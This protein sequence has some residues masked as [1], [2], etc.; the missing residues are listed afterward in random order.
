MPKSEEI[1]SEDSSSFTDEQV[2]LYLLCRLNEGERV[3]FEERLL[4]GDE[5]AQR[6]R[7]AE[8]ELSDDYAADRLSLADRDFFE[9]KF[10]VSEGRRSDLRVSQALHKHAA[11]VS[12]EAIQT[13]KS[14][15]LQRVSAL[16]GFE[17]SPVFATVGSL[18]MLILIGGAVWL[19]VRQKQTQEPVVASYENAPS[20]QP[21]VSP[22]NQLSPTQ[23]APSPQPSPDKKPPTSPTPPHAQ[24]PP[25]VATFTLFPGSLRGSGD[26]LR[27]VV[28]SGKQDVVRLMLVPE[29]DGKGIYGAQ[30]LSA[31]G[32]TILTR[33]RLQITKDNSEPRLLLNIPAHQ[34]KVGDYQIRLSR[35]LDGKIE[36]IG[37]Y[38]FR[39]L[40]K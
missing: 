30:L 27:V 3:K 17:R 16:F 34:L 39:A 29:A 23:P 14:S 37:S 12:P 25:T 6:T 20:P 22:A 9:K 15:W 11:V 40:Q 33:A 21:S 10:L 35:Q 18:A 1:G 38:Y 13:E 24:A 36:V 4:V 19:V 31:E 8:L 7:L 5:L 2:R 32:K 28:P 26:L